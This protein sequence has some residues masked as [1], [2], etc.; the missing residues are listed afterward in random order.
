MDV[1]HIWLLYKLIFQVYFQKI[2]EN[3]IFQHI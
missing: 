1:I 2:F 3:V